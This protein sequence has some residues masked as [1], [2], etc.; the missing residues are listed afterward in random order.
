MQSVAID[1]Q[2]LT[3]IPKIKRYGT[4]VVKVYS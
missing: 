4:K 2:F 3:E 1:G